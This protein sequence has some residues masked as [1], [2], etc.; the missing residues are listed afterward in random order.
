[1][2]FHRWPAIK[3]SAIVTHCDNLATLLGAISCPPQLRDH[4]EFSAELSLGD[5]AHFAGADIALRCSQSMDWKNIE[6]RRTIIG[7]VVCWIQRAYPD[8]DNSAIAEYIALLSLWSKGKMT[9]ELIGQGDALSKEV[10]AMSA[11]PPHT[12]DETAIIQIW[13]L[14]QVVLGEETEVDRWTNYGAASVAIVG[15]QLISDARDDP[16]EMTRQIRDIVER[17]PRT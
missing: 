16:E 12:S 15:S 11:E 9:S 13:M 7:I 6:L 2:N 5:I 10:M 17:F 1:M 14:M 4:G 3:R 8:I